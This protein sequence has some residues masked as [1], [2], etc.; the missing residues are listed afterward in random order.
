MSLPLIHCDHQDPKS[1]TPSRFLA[2]SALSHGKSLPNPFLSPPAARDLVERLEP[3]RRVVSEPMPILDAPAEAVATGFANFI[4]NSRIV[5]D[6]TPV[7]KLQQNANN[8]TRKRNRNKQAKKG[9][10]NPEPV[11]HNWTSLKEKFE[12]PTLPVASGS[13]SKTNGGDDNMQLYDTKSDTTES[14]IFTKPDT[15]RKPTITKPDLHE[16][17]QR[18]DD[19]KL[20][21]KLT[22]HNSL[23]GSNDTHSKA[24]YAARHQR[25]E[26]PHTTLTNSYQNEITQSKLKNDPTY[27]HSRS[28]YDDSNTTQKPNETAKSDQDHPIVPVARRCSDSQ[29]RDRKRVDRAKANSPSAWTHAKR[30]PTEPSHGKSVGHIYDVSSTGHTLI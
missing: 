16:K 14:P 23:P 9:F 1:T 2:S 28:P 21:T 18:P 4:S 19:T 12:F 30:Q 5:S 10:P 26:P 6:P 24:S 27:K 17:Q 11:V 25:D 8:A 13:G 29:A 7:P 3:G 22:L 15:D 20:K